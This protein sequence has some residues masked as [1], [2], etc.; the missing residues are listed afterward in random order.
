M[1]FAHVLLAEASGHCG[2]QLRKLGLTPIF[3]CLQCRREFVVLAQGVKVAAHG[4]VSLFRRA[5][6][7][8]GDCCLLMKGGDPFGKFYH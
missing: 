3:K 8:A 2:L 1:T 6:L 5:K 7:A 4:S